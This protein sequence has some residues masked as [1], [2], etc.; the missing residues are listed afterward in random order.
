V[1]KKYFFCKKTV[2]ISSTKYEPFGKRL[3]EAVAGCL[4]REEAAKLARLC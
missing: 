3:F 2:E 1:V 4:T